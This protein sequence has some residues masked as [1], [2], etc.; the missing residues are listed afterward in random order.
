MR[1]ERS[2]ECVS[3]EGRGDPRLVHCGNTSATCRSG[4]GR[5]MGAATGRGLTRQALPRR[6]GGWG[7]RGYSTRL[8]EAGSPLMWRIAQ[9]CT[10]G[11]FV[12]MRLRYLVPVPLH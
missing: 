11:A 4:E 12:G 7:E 2:R 3:T 8:H 5:G 6:G 9:Y 10:P 1:V